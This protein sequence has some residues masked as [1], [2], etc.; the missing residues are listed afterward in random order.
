LSIRAKMK[1][2]I[3]INGGLGRQICSIPA[4]EKLQKTNDDFIIIVEG[5]IE[6]FQGHPELYKKTYPI[7]NKNL[8]EDHIKHCETVTPE[9]YR[10]HSYFNQQT[11]LIQAFDEIINQTTDHTDLS[12]PRL[13]L[14]KE[15]EVLAASIINQAKSTT[16]KNKIV[17]VQPFGRSTVYQNGMLYDKSSRSFSKELYL[18]LTKRLSEFYCVIVMS[19]FPIEEDTW[20]FK[21]ANL[22]VR[23][24]MALIES[25]NYFIGCDSSGQHIA[26]SFNKPGTVILG[27]TFSENVSYPDHFQILEK[28]QRKVYSPIRINDS[29]PDADL[30]DRANDTIMDFDHIEIDNLYKKIQIDIEKTTSRDELTA[31]TQFTQQPTGNT[32]C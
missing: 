13:F 11:H 21:P 22:N 17:I 7:W 10:L 30:A 29:A 4:L 2:A 14:N 28:N 23:A 6:A 31:P 19:E 3:F 27:S 12:S 1:K 25:C 15:E 8:F 24:Y 5:I 26:H 9:P 20:S 18:E 16:G 32:C